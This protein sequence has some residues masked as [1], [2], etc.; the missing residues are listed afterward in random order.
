[1]RDPG[2]RE[3]AEGASCL[4]QLPQ[5]VEPARLLSDQVSDPRTSRRRLSGRMPRKGVVPTSG[6]ASAITVL[7]KQVVQRKCARSVVIAG[8]VACVTGC[9]LLVGG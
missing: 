7:G 5:Q 9:D 3:E 4:P 2:Q 6:P 1:M 8:V